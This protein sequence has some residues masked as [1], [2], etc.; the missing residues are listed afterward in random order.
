MV[1]NRDVSGKHE[2]KVRTADGSFR[3]KWYWEVYVSSSGGDDFVKA[4]R[5][6]ILRSCHGA[7]SERQLG[8]YGDCTLSGRAAPA[9][10]QLASSP[11][12][13][14]RIGHLGGFEP[15]LFPEEPKAG[16]PTAE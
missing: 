2:F 14:V 13:M 4:V 10:F 7:A 5:E 3:H 1:I 9:P 11:P 16:S 6:G 8:R 15:L 12:G